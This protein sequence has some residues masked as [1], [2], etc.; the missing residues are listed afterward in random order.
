MKF[1]SL[2][3]KRKSA[4]EMKKSLIMAVGSKLSE[5]INKLWIKKDNLVKPNVEICAKVEKALE[6]KIIEVEA[7]NQMKILDIDEIV[8]FVEISKENGADFQGNNDLFEKQVIEINESQRQDVKI[9]EDLIKDSNSQEVE[10]EN[11]LSFL[12]MTVKFVCIILD[13][14]RMK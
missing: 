2:R 14:K 12:K 4:S 10:V 1:E 9:E 7:K 6:E 8:K 11:F 13:Q 3:W 5:V